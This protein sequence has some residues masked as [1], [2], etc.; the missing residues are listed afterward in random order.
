MKITSEH[1]A[2]GPDDEAKSGGI[3][4][5]DI[6]IGSAE[7]AAQRLMGSAERLYDVGQELAMDAA[8]TGD[9]E[10]FV[11]SV[12]A[13]HSSSERANLGAGILSK[14]TPPVDDLDKYYPAKYYPADDH[15]PPIDYEP[16]IA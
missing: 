8:D 10:A 12:R 5:A 7:T 2:L 16:P 6:T 4:D 1:I 3:V 13:L 9:R 11:R 15:F 14:I